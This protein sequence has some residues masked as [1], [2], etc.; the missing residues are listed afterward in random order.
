MNALLTRFARWLL[1]H[2][3]RQH[4]LGYPAELQQVIT[5]G[6]ETRYTFFQLRYP[7]TSW[8]ESAA[9][10]WL[11]YRRPPRSLSWAERSYPY[12]AFGGAWLGGLGV[13][14]YSSARTFTW[15][16][17]SLLVCLSIFLWQLLRDTWQEG[18]DRWTRR[19]TRRQHGRFQH[20]P[21]VLMLEQVQFFVITWNERVVPRC[22]RWQQTLER[23]PPQL[24]SDLEQALHEAQVA[25]QTFLEL[26][27]D[28][29]RALSAYSL[30]QGYD[31]RKQS[32][33]VAESRQ[34]TNRLH[35]WRASVPPLLLDESDKTSWQ[36]KDR[37]ANTTLTIR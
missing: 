10:A 2:G 36:L 16:T 26:L 33:L 6:E 7:A 25:R 24:L 37:H 27:A 4:N 22:R 31:P 3:S 12:L 8:S 5:P 21:R 11:K 13:G 18:Q 34:F 19:L 17:S 1:V 23:S 14:Y 30:G 9:W 28:L 35:A 20:D 29:E 15:F 32:Q